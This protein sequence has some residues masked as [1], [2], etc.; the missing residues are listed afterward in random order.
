MYTYYEG[1]EEYLQDAMMFFAW[2]VVVSYHFS[3][4]EHIIP[5]L[6]NFRDEK[7]MRKMNSATVFSFI[8]F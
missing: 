5:Y 8:N 4:V 6:C 3:L 1:I 7:K 2:T